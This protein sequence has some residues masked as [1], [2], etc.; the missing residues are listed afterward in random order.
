MARAGAAAA[1]VLTLVAPALA[2]HAEPAFAD[3]VEREFAIRAWAL[4]REPEARSRALDGDADA[5]ASVLKALERRGRID[6]SPIDAD[7]RE[8]IAGALGEQQAAEPQ[9][10]AA[11][12]R[13]AAAHGIGLADAE[14]DSPLRHPLPLV[15]LAAI[16]CARVERHE[17]RLVELALETDERVASAARDALALALPDSAGALARV[18]AE[19][20]Q[21]GDPAGWNAIA[22]RL[23][24]CPAPRPLLADLARGDADRE[25]S[26]VVEALRLRWHGAA[27]VAAVARAW[28]GPEGLEP[29]FVAAAR[30]THAPQSELGVALLSEAERCEDEARLRALVRGV[31][32]ALPAGEV[33]AR[34]AASQRL[35]ERVGEQVLE[36]LTVDAD[37][38]HAEDLAPWL[39]ASVSAALRRG[40]AGLLQ[41][42]LVDDRRADVAPLLVRAL[43]DRDAAVVD[44]AFEALCDARPAE[45]WLPALYSRWRRLDEGRALAALAELPRGVRLEP[46]QA[47][48]CGIAAT[49]GGASLAAFELLAPLAPDA[50][51]AQV[52]ARRLDEEL[53]RLQQPSARESE[54]RAAGLV[55][56]LHEHSG[57]SEL[58]RLERVLERMRERVEVSK[59]AA[60]ALGQSAAGRER[61]A[62]WIA[63]DVPSR[64]RIE[65]ALARAPHGDERAVAAL[66]VDWEGCDFELRSRM[67]AAWGA[68]ESAAALAALRRVALDGGTSE[69][70]R[71]LAL[72]M[73]AARRP[74]DFETLTEA[75]A[76]RNLDLRRHALLAIG[77]CGHERAVGWLR[78]RL[79][80][81]ELSDAT[82][83]A[84]AAHEVEREALWTALA[85]LGAVDDELESAWL[86]GPL[87]AAPEQLRARFVGRAQ[88][89]TGFVWRAELEVA[90]ALARERRLLAALERAGAWWRCDARLL[91]AIG[92]TALEQRD[93]AAARELFRA[94]GIGLLGEAEGEE[95]EARR[96][97]VRLGL[98]AACEALGDAASFERVARGLLEDE[99]VGRGP[100]RAFEREFG[101]FDPVRELDGCARLRAAI[102]QAA[103]LELAGRGEL[104][105]A[106][107]R[108]TESAALV[109]AS[110]AARE[111]QARLE[112]ALARAR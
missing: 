106:R 11:A 67:L 91:A 92:S 80:A 24:R 108:A 81:L 76:D 41:S 98:L 28:P 103:A 15:R 54:L 62:K 82:P 48:L 27:D 32:E 107:R 20:R 22:A 10:L 56:A 59:V 40:A 104:E 37:G 97:E 94:A 49:R 17:E 112:E 21:R 50:G 95:R 12:L 47:D 14:L 65:A 100:R 84:R 7:E 45:P 61:L 4:R 9:V 78:E 34:V 29:V 79:G 16:E 43:E 90:R 60:W 57:G 42:M 89:G 13:A 18:A 25:R 101:A 55:R 2:Q 74:P 73:L 53:E 96:F 77:G 111:A 1:L 87:A 35:A 102:P 52:A 58:E 26:A 63:P 46:F 8:A 3:S 70:H 85:R 66:V 75:A 71:E 33:L 23:E 88:G 31:V 105:L 64:L 99:L 36:V 5:R 51:I 86:V 39:D 30:A 19:L 93:F 6:G 69:L 68:S 83:A 44:I 38:L 72:D 109:G 110:R